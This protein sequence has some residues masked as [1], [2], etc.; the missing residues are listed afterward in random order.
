MLHS[1]NHF[2]VKGCMLQDD[3]FSKTEKANWTR[4]FYYEKYS[5]LSRYLFSILF[6]AMALLLQYALAPYIGFRPYFLVYP[7]AFIVATLMGFWPAVLAVILLGL[8]GEFF[9][10]EPRFM[11][12]FSSEEFFRV[13]IYFFVTIATIKLITFRHRRERK[14]AEYLAVLENSE[15]KFRMMADKAPVLI[16]ISNAQK[17]F[18]WFN[19]GWLNFT[20]KTSEEELGN[21]RVDEIHPDD[22]IKYLET[23]QTHFT[24]RSEFKIEYRLKHHSGEY[25][26]IVDHG[27]PRFD[28]NGM[29]QGFIGASVDI[30]ESKLL[31]DKL[32]ENEDRMKSYIDSMPQ[33]VFIADKEG[34]IIHWNQRWFHY[35][36][37]AGDVHGWEWKNRPIHHPDD[38]QRTIE[39]WTESVRTGRPYQIEYRLRRHDGEYRWHLGRAEA[40]RNERGEIIQWFGTNT[41]IHEHKLAEEK[42]AALNILIEKEKAKYETIFSSSPVAIAV[43]RGKDPVFEMCNKEYLKLIGKTD[44]IGKHI[45]EVL[46]EVQSQ[47]FLKYLDGVFETGV[48]FEGKEAPLYLTKEDGRREVKYLDFIYQRIEESG[49]PYGI[50]VQVVDTTD[51]VLAR[52]KLEESEKRFRTIAEAVPGIVFSADANGKGDYFSSRWYEMTGQTPGQPNDF[53]RIIHPDDVKRTLDKW[54]NCVETGDIFENECRIRI[55]NLKEYRWFL[56]RAVPFRN[57]QGEIIKWF[58]HHTEIHELR[59]TQEA[60]Q[61]SVRARDEFLSIASHELKTPLTSLKLQHQVMIKSMSKSTSPFEER[62]VAVARQTD[63]QISKLDRLIDDMLDVSRIRAGKLYINREWFEII[64]FVYEISERM[65]IHFPDIHFPDTSNGNEIQVHWDKLRI[66]QV[67]VNLLTNAI[68]YGNKKPITVKVFE[69]NGTVNISVIDKGI[70]IAENARE[71]IFSRF[72]RAVSANEVSGLGLGLFITKQIVNAHGG[73]VRVESELGEGSTFI[74]EIPKVEKESDESSNL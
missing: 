22:K 14:L 72:E 59:L 58:G 50:F 29:F 42:L 60:L 38:L 43:V 3:K 5:Y 70:G 53:A 20:G 6:S 62:I 15:N 27:V 69:Q 44:I 12:T 65:K 16:W 41:D 32:R 23:Y 71:K 39:T 36:R 31:Q 18:I 4:H 13:S 35:A 56:S 68:R 54:Q 9:I 21:S 57:D 74:V 37:E 46:P 8:G 2:Y 17:K 47:P 30:H 24:E 73:S 33:M 40:L 49:K 48:P 10:A 55:E 34:N 61:E 66:E 26:W 28:E 1:R 45:L 51:K 25:R 64:D 52:K 67:L 19:Q 7:A 11:F 63:K